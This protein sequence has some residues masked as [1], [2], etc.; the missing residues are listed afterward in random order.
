MSGVVKIEINESAETLKKLLK[1]ASIPQN[2]EI[3]KTIYWLKT[4]TVETVKPIAIM[5]GRNRIIVQKWLHKYR[6]GA[7]NLWLEPKKNLGGRPSLIPPNV[8]EKL[9][10][11]LQNPDMFPKLWFKFNCG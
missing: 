4:Q 2:K 11:E 3:I 1:K 7:L 8:T 9:E 10:E 6:T 5:W